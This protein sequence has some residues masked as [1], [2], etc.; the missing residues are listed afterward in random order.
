MNATSMD[1]P[2]VILVVVV[3]R[4]PRSHAAS[5]DSQKLSL[6]MSWNFIS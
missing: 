1:G 3:M 4:V 6:K 5:I 2:N